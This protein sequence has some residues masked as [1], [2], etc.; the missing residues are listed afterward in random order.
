[1]QA[2]SDPARPA[3]PSA[4]VL[5]WH[6]PARGLRGLLSGQRLRAWWLRRLP[7]QDQT[8]LQHGNLYLLP[9]RAGWMLA[10]TLLLILLGSINYQLNL[11][12]LLTFLLAGSAAAGVWVGH[13][14]LVGLSLS[15]HPG[16]PV[17]AGQSAA[18]EIQLRNPSRRARYAVGLQ[19]LDHPHAS[20]SAPS[21][22]VLAGA[23]GPT[24]SD[25]WA[26]V[27]PQDQHTVHLAY[28]TQRR[29]RH[30]LPALRVQTVF[31][32]GTFKVWHWWCPAAQLW[33]YPAPEVPAPPLPLG[34]HADDGPAQRQAGSRHSD[35]AQDVR[36]YRRGDPLKWVLWK[37]AARLAGSAQPQWLS[38]DFGLPSAAELWLD[39]SRCGLA[40]EEARRARLCAWV[41]QAE[42]QGLRYGLRLPGLEIAPDHGPAQRR[43]CLE[44]LAWR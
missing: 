16:E 23:G 11:G 39:A 3:A 33:V 36:P 34:L 10:L 9:T 13:R 29:G 19:W 35:E 25:V 7:P 27:D 1:M 6:A 4:G 14:N 28:P 44:A 20:R 43:R 8:D 5:R 32:L 37:K 26:D 30:S 41:L 38:R 40:D 21:A 15:L 42:A 22:G 2:A 31:P 17:F 24:A 18:I 12:Y